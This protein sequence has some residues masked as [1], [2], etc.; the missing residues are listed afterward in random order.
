MKHPS[1]SF[2]TCCVK[3]RK[4]DV[5]A[6]CGEFPCPK[7]EGWDA[8]DS[9]V[10]HL[11]SISNLR[12]AR[13]QGVKAFIAGQKKRMSL[14]DIML[15][16]FND[17]KSKSFYCLAAALLPL[18]SLEKLLKKAEKETATSDI[19]TKA[20]SLRGLLYE[21]AHKEGIWLRLRKGT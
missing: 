14:L 16:K 1:C 5:C 12:S 20:D 17:G 4:L 15:K 8:C 10:T 18:K 9:F 2:I 7:F 3:K 19:K 21:L 13:E 6:Q 11:K